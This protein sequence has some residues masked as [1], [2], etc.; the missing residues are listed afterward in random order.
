MTTLVK[1]R[2]LIKNLGS[3]A[4]EAG[5]EFTFVRHGGSHD[6][7]SLDGCPITIPRHTEL[8]ELL[9]RGILREAERYLAQER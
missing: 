5:V 1:K 3:L 4:R 7:F 2:D 8:N 9:A 6:L